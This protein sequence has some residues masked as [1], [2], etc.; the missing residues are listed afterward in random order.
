MAGASLQRH[1]PPPI[2]F[3]D[4]LHSVDAFDDLTTHGFVRVA[5]AIPE[6]RIADPAH[7]AAQ[8]T[9]LLCRAAGQGAS[10]CVFPELGLTA[11]TCEDL[12][13]QRALLDAALV[14]LDGIRLAT[15]TLPTIAVVGLPLMR[16]VA[17]SIDSPGGS[18]LGPPPLLFA[19]MLHVRVVSW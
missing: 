15:T 6:V 7:N 18:A 12:F 14:A 16:P 19:T 9:E 4:T 1:H 10:L 5:V 11:Y 3:A 8:T 2:A 17:L 13:H